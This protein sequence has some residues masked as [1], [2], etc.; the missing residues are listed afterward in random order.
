[1][2]QKLGTE[3]SLSLTLS[4]EERMRNPVLY[5]GYE[6]ETSLWKLI[7]LYQGSLEA[8][9]EELSITIIPL[10]GSF[11]IIKIPAE[12]IPLLL[13]HPQVLYLELPRPLY[14]EKITG[15]SAS[16]F[17]DFPF[18]TMQSEVNNS[19]LTGR[20][21]A[22]GILDSGV[23]Y[24]H[25]DFRLDSGD[26]RILI[27]WDQ[28]LSY[29]GINP[30]YLGRIFTNEALNELLISSLDSSASKDLPRPSADA[31][32]HG[33]H[34]AGRCAGNGRA[35]NGKNQGAAPEAS[36]IVVKLKN[37]AH[38]VFTDYANLMM[39]TDFAV[40]FAANLSIPLCINISYG[41][42]D[43][44]HDGTGLIERFLSQ[45]L[46]YGKNTISVATGNEGLSGRHSSFQITTGE[47]QD[48]AF[49]VA[50]GE[51]SLYLQ[52]WKN[53]AD[54]FDYSLSL[55]NQNNKIS[56]PDT[57]GI[58]HFSEKQNDIRVVISEPTPYQ[59]LQEMF[60]VLLPTSGETAIQSGIWH[61]TVSSKKSVNGQA[62]LWL[63]AKEATNSATG[64]LD[65]ATD[66]SLTV[67]STA[68]NVISVSG[69]DS[70]TDTFAAFSGRGFSNPQ[71]AKPDLTA[72]AVNILST[73]PGGGYSIRTG[74]SMAAP[75]V[76]G[77]AALLMQYG[78]VDGHDPFLY[79]EKIKALLQKGARPLPAFKEYP[80][81]STGWGALCFQSSI[82]E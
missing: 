61:L 20:G 59:Q 19:E 49:S 63:P 81:A 14:Q 31:S 37:D 53:Y 2:N 36:L 74:T 78:I 66:L 80:N 1:M 42:N 76:T 75:F 52:L 38:S 43:G 71:N 58:F 35:S 16:C 3:L 9:R 12:Q 26:S 47:K 77:A 18:S 10:L 79:G 4:D 73:A 32:G 64:F 70:I 28:S 34:V 5:S 48:I 22:V 27:Y 41:S 65:A 51:T 46:F 50:P 33:T 69:Y 72:P 57:P 45:C 82:P 55:P 40:R 15:I 56:I 39:A 62:N 68:A 24:R 60:L 21:T 54:Q 44:P 67:P 17:S 29:D 23:D 13:Q 25:P 8:I 7:L 30:Y 6:P 11:A